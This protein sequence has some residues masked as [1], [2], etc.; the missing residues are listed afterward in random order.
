MI[1]CGDLRFS[2]SVLCIASCNVEI[3]R[4]SRYLI[5]S[6]FLSILLV[7]FQFGNGRALAGADLCLGNLDL[8]FNIIASKHDVNQRPAQFHLFY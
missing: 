1:G 3:S 2:A 8:N 6:A 7:F 4:R 5:K